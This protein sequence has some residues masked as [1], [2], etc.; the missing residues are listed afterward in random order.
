VSYI[1]L[2][3][4]FAVIGMLD[5]ARKLE[6]SILTSIQEQPL[7]AE[8]VSKIWARESKQF[9]S[10]YAETMTDNILTF[11]CVPKV[12]MFLAEYDIEPTKTYEQR[13]KHGIQQRADT[14]EEPAG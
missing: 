6:M 12:E 4:L 11:T 13:I 14:V 1:Q 10:R 8:Q 9:P 2:A 5:T 3:E 7:E